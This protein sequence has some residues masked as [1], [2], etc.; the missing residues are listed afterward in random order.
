MIERLEATL[1]KY[2]KLQEELTKT[3]VLSYLNNTAP[4]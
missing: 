3:E 1:E 2:N 4:N